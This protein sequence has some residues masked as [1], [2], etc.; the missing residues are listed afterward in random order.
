VK[1]STDTPNHIVVGLCVKVSANFSE[2]NIRFSQL[3]F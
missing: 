1:I 3:F 2:R